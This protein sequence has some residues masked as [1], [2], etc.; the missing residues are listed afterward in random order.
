MSSA[1]LELGCC[2]FGA[3]IELF[4]NALSQPGA[5][6]RDVETDPDRQ[7][8]EKERAN[9]LVPQA[10]RNVALKLRGTVEPGKDG[11]YPAVCFSI[12]GQ[13]S[14][15]QWGITHPYTRVVVNMMGHSPGLLKIYSTYEGMKLTKRFNARIFRVKNKMVDK[16]FVVRSE[17][18][19]LAARI[20][21]PEHRNR[22]FAM[23][24]RVP[25]GWAGRIDLSRGLFTVFVPICLWRAATVLNLVGLATEL[26]ARSREV[27]SE[28]GIALVEAKTADS[29][30]CQVCGTEM[31]DEIVHCTRCGTPHHEECWL[32]M[33]RCSTF[34]CG[35]VRFKI[36]A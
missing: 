30:E 19:T 28:A 33:E 35:E 17:P 22:L 24:G 11:A 36:G 8:R 2:A 7:E 21:A 32:Y 5:P 25:R 6:R 14:E 26:L 13:E 10:A 15:V 27:E 3:L 31:S 34:G 1:A 20:F 23:I 18:E 9:R 29:G 4:M 16:R 12:H